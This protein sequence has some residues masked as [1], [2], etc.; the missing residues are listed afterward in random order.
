MGED[1]PEV[2]GQGARRLSANRLL[3]SG[4]ALP[5]ASAGMSDGGNMANSWQERKVR[6]AAVALLA[7]GTLGGCA[8]VKDLGTAG[9]MRDPSAQPSQGTPRP[10]TP[11]QGPS[12][13]GDAMQ[14]PSAQPPQST[15]RPI[16]PDQGPNRTGD[17][18]QDPSAQPSQ[19]TPRPR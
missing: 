9:A 1:L 13:T 7:L 18:M 16:T 11:N 4:V 3:P 15:P 10:I 17:A 6:C 14:D 2:D 19:S 12:R 5:S 8:D